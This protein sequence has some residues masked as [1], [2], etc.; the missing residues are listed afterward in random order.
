MLSAV[1][2]PTP[3]PPDAYPINSF[4]PRKRSPPSRS[5]SPIRKRQA[6]TQ[7]DYIDTREQELTERFRKREA[8]EPRTEEEKNEAAKKEYTALLGKRSGGVYLAPARLRALQAQISDKSSKEYQRMV[9]E[10][11]KKAINGNVNKVNVRKIPCHRPWILR[12]PCLILSR[13]PTSSIW[14]ARYSQ[15]I[16]YVAVGS[17]ASLL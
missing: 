16:S 13:R 1:R 12:K 10:A 4:V 3:P 6:P 9:W 2:L 17:S 7:N 15:K 8:P 11:L 5:P 14:S